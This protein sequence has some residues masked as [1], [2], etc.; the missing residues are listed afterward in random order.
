MS[1]GGMNK[2]SGDKVQ[3]AVILIASADTALRERCVLGLQTAFAVHQVSRRT[4]L[5]H[6]LTQIKPAVLLLDLDLPQIGDIE[7]VAAIQHL[8][9]STNIIL[10]LLHVEW[11]KMSS[12]LTETLSHTRV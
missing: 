8:C 12:E 6:A 4:E 11:V 2:K 3:K 5:E 1:N 10:D 7:G 9:P